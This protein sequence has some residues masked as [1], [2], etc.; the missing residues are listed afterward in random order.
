VTEI[1]IKDKLA[2]DAFKT[3]NQSHL[4]VD[5]EIC[6]KCDT[7]CCL[8]VCPARVYTLDEEGKIKVEFE[9]CLECGTCLMACPDDA[10]MWNYPRG[11]FG[12]QYRYG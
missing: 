4:E 1:N 3:D 6:R 12:V 8:Y 5:Q 2:L 7:K 9:A 11:G 10:I